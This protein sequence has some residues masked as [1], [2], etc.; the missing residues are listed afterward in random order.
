[1]FPAFHFSKIAFITDGEQALINS[2]G[3]NFPE[4]S[5]LRWSNHIEQNMI[6]NLRKY[7]M[8]YANKTTLKRKHI[9]VCS[10]ERR[11]SKSYSGRMHE[12]ICKKKFKKTFFN[13]YLNQCGK[14][15]VLN[16]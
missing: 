9:Y 15:K 4:N 16:L 6:F 3:K 8:S 11:S 12:K 1:M 2:I 5:K 13:L 14:E 7:K 10:D